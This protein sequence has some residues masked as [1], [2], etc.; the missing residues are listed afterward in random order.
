MS[1]GPTGGDH[2]QPRAV[3]KYWARMMSSLCPEFQQSFQF[4]FLPHIQFVDRVRDIPGVR[5]DVVS[6]FPCIQQSL[7]SAVLLLRSATVVLGD[8]YSCDR[9]RRFC[10]VRQWIHG[11]RQS[12]AQCLVP[13]WILVFPSSEAVWDEFPKMTSDSEVWHSSCPML[14]ST[15]N[16]RSAGYVLY[17]FCW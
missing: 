5:R 6:S 14:G 7:S 17:W 12:S 15:L 3:H 2:R 16:T 11:L 13:Q 4:L 8:D 10:L 1:S 9:I